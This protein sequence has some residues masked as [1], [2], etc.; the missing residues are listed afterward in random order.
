MDTMEQGLPPP[1]VKLDLAFGISV[2]ANLIRSR[3]IDQNVVAL[4]PVHLEGRLTVFEVARL[5]THMQT[6][7]NQDPN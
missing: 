2:Y 7:P 5:P 4:R 6:V 3:V 1:Q